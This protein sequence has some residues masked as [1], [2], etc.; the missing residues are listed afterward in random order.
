MSLITKDDHTRRKGRTK[1]RNEPTSP[2]RQRFILSTEHPLERSAA[3]ASACK[4]CTKSAAVLYKHL[5]R[6]V[7]RPLEPEGVPIHL[8]MQSLPILTL[9]RILELGHPYT[10]S[11]KTSKTLWFLIL[12]GSRCSFTTSPEGRR[13]HRRPSRLDP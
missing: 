9:V 4:F 5:C 3:E 11:L 12:Q 1:R 10:T 2:E 7:G 8:K 6:R 13:P